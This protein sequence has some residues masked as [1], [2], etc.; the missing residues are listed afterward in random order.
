MQTIGT[1]VSKAFI[2]WLKLSSSCKIAARFISYGK[3]R[4]LNMSINLIM[5]MKC[6]ISILISTLVPGDFVLGWNLVDVETIKRETTK[7]LKPRDF[8]CWSQGW[9]GLWKERHLA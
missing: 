2:R 6:Q 8:E 9:R 1:I 4:S 5:Q 7:L 3:N